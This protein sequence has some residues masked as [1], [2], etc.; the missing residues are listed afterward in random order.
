MS[1]KINYIENV[2]DIL[3]THKDKLSSY[4]GVEH[5]D[6][7]VE[8]IAYEYEE[9]HK[10]YLKLNLYSPDTASIKKQ[11]L[12]KFKN[13]ILK[14]R[15]TLVSL[16]Q[17]AFFKLMSLYEKNSRTF[18]KKEK[19]D[20]G[21]LLLILNNLNLSSKQL[22]DNL[23]MNNKAPFRTAHRQDDL[24]LAI[25]LKWEN[26]NIDLVGGT[27]SKFIRFCQLVFDLLEVKVSKPKDYYDRLKAQKRIIIK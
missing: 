20:L 19:M 18:G 15:D 16:D 7:W 2:K 11:K 23:S 9:Q 1:L 3:N 25:Y 12:T 14:T 17:S 21:Q 4:V 27:N 5:V 13:S 22:I 24:F 10:H 6:D 26:Q 8:T